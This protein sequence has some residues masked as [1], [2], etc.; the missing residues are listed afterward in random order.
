MTPL[1]AVVLLIG[2][3]IVGF[4]LLVGLLERLIGG[5]R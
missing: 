5:P 1:G 3:P 2:G 4:V